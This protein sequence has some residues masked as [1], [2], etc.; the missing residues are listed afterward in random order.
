M[1][2]MAARVSGLP[3]GG[4]VVCSA[5]TF[6]KMGGSCEGAELVP[7]GMHKLKGI[8]EAV[9]VY[10]V[11]PKGLEGRALAPPTAAPQRPTSK[12]ARRAS[13]QSILSMGSTNFSGGGG[14]TNG[15]KISNGVLMLAKVVLPNT[16][17]GDMGLMVHATNELV[18]SVLLVSALHAQGCFCRKDFTNPL[19]SW[20][21]V[22]FST[23]VV[24][25][26]LRTSVCWENIWLIQSTLERLCDPVSLHG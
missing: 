11:I 12:Q 10:V 18:A 26:T 25:S 20:R 6:R 1:V 16:G 15:M 19:P 14:P 23:P 5:A 4:Q 8:T 3:V 24:L 22:T 7:C 13:K 2:N 17:A 21:G 9:D